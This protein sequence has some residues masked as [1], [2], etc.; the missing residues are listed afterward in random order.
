MKANP[1]KR[2]RPWMWILGAIVLLLAALIILMNLDFTPPKTTVVATGLIDGDF[3]YTL[4]S[5]KTAE[6]TKYLGSDATVTVPAKVGG[7]T[8]TSLGTDEAEPF[9]D[10]EKLLSVTVSEGIAKIGAAAFSGCKKLTSVSLPASV[11]EI[12]A[13]AFYLCYDLP[14]ITTPLTVTTALPATGV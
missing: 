5:D 10:N 9:R 2:I 1:L 4:Y 7:A 13:S 6:I 12:G 8:V 11:T 3:E 14:A